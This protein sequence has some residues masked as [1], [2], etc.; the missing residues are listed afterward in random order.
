MDF[1]PVGE[2]TSP[3]KVPVFRYVN[4]HPYT[5]HG[6]PANPAHFAL[7]KEIA[8]EVLA[9]QQDG[10]GEEELKDFLHRLVETM[11]ATPEIN[12]Q[13]LSELRRYLEAAHL[14]LVRANARKAGLLDISAKVRRRRL[15]YQVEHI[16][17]NT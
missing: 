1:Q 10:Y 6:A 16:R 13:A 15:T 7:Y 11:D 2:S 3:F 5:K 14:A 9:G 12:S 4:L 17:L 8:S